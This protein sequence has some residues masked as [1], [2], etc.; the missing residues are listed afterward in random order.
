MKKICIPVH[1]YTTEANS[2]ISVWN[3]AF[4]FTG[5]NW[6]N[7]YDQ[8]DPLRSFDIVFFNF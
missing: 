2:E 3:F 1:P 7:F 5:V 8:K 6:K 4:Y